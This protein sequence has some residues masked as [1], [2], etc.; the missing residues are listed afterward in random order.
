MALR[1]LRLVPATASARGPAAGVQRV[2]RPRRPGIAGQTP[3]PRAPEAPAAAP[4]SLSRR[5][6]RNRDAGALEPGYPLAR[7][8]S[9]WRSCFVER[10]VVVT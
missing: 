5:H 2:V 9:D 8:F 3:A 7:P 4:G 1:L 10:P 6:S